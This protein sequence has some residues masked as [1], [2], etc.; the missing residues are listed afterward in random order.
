MSAQAL[1]EFSLFP[2]K[3]LP[4]SRLIRMLVPCC[5]VTDVIDITAMNRNIYNL[6]EHLR[7]HTLLFEGDENKMALAD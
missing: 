4:T 2:D 5:L 3:I 6:R 1:R 7:S